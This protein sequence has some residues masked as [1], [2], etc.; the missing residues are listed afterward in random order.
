MPGGRLR[1]RLGYSLEQ[2]VNRVT[3]LPA[4]RFGLTDRGVLREGAFADIVVFD[5]D[6]I[7]DLASFEDPTA[8]P[9]GIPHVLVNG[10]FVVRDGGLTGE[11]PGRVVP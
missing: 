11:L 6:Q 10:T 1:R 3:G 9:V 2:V 5:A 8:P 4:S 7:A